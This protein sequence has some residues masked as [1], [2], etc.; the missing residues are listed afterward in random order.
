M[1]RNCIDENCVKR[2]WYNFKGDVDALYC[3]LHKKDDMENVRA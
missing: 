2:A 1:P 3:G